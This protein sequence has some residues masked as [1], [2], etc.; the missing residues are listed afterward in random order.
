MKKVILISLGIVVVLL[1]VVFVG[2]PALQANLTGGAAQSG[3]QTEAAR[4]GSISVSVG[5]AGAVRANQL[6]AIVW[7]TSGKVGDVTVEKGQIV[8]AD[9]VLATLDAASLSQ[10]VLQAQVDRV[11]AKAALD[12]ALNNSAA[13]ADA[14]LALIQAQQA[15]DEAE[16]DAQSKLFRRASQ[17]TIDI[18]RSNLI[19]ANEALEQAEQAF[20]E[21]NGAGEGSLVYA[22]ALSRRAAAR[23]EAR[24]AE[25]NLRYVQGLPDPLE[26]EE[27]N[28]KLAQAQA[29]L[30][31][32]QHN[33]DKIKD[34]ADA[35]EVLAAQV[36]LDIAQAT[37]D[38]ARLSAPFSGTIMQVDI[39]PGDLVNAGST[40]FHIADLSRLSV[41]ADISEVDIS[42]VDVGLPVSIAFDALFGQ[43][44]VG[45]VTDIAAFG[46][47]SGG[48]VNFTVTIE[49][50]DPVEDILPGMTAAVYI[51]ASQLDNILLVP[52][53]A[54]R[55]V[56]G[57][58]VVYVLQDNAPV[59]VEITLGASANQYSQV[60]SGDVRAGDLIILNP[61][62]Q[63]FPNGPGGGGMFGGGDQ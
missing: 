17:E 28:A 44:F 7:Q 8:T 26:V 56:D 19:I 5:G 52:S 13:R 2:L 49:L 34:G 46:V 25:Y 18:A 33:W 11:N 54:I 3:F 62:T 15:L 22:N 30:L 42:Q 48:V 60:V 4:S 36:R 6:A 32:A 10:Q 24:R 61:P 9:T 63:M 1:L 43:E 12:E 55:T 16:R 21:I 59:A 38:T 27:V 20:D 41:D 23:Q 31:T 35:D 29:Q 47:T 37:L 57:N 51:T 58:R 39:R 53:R 40:A 14:N 50:L 45:R